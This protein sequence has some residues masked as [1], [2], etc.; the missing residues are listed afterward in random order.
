MSRKNALFESLLR[1]YDDPSHL[2]AFTTY[3]CSSRESPVSLRLLD[4]LVTNYA[5]KH[6]V[7]YSI[8]NADGTKGSFNMFMDYKSQLKAYSK[9]FFDPF[10]RRE[11]I[12]IRNSDGVLQTTTVA[13]MNFVRWMIM[14]NVG[15]YA[16][17]H[18]DSIEKD[19]VSVSRK[20]KEEEKTKRHE[21]ST[22]AIKNCTKTFCHV[23]VRFE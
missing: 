20:A 1:F 9:R 8:E 19:M 4:W 22:A 3:T 7:V 23:T 15:E 14:K 18:Q 6:N 12:E 11:R 2:K 16:I 5:K 13:Q 10:C 17:R 21:L